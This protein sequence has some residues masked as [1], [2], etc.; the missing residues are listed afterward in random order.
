M[1][2]LVNYFSNYLWLGIVAFL[3]A[4]LLAR[5]LL[6]MIIFLSREKNLMDAPGERSAHFEKTPNL[7]GAGIF[8]AFSLSILILAGSFH[9]FLGNTNE[10]LILLAA[11]TITFFL[12]VKDD[13]I[14]ISAK[15]KLW[16]QNMAVSLVIL[17][18][19]LRI[20][21]LGGL[22]GI[23]EIPYFLSIVLT[24]L[25]F[26]FLINAFNLTD[27]VDGLASTVGILAC[28]TFG[29]FFLSAGKGL[30]GLLCI[31]LAGALLAFL[32]YN[33]SRKSKIFMGDSGSL[34]IGFMI[35]YLGIR[36]LQPGSSETAGLLI[37]D[38]YLPVLAVLSFPVTDTLRVAVLRL[39]RRRNPFKADRNHI[40]HRFLNSGFSHRQTTLFISLYNLFLIGLMIGLKSINIHLAF[41]I[42]I[43]LMCGYACLPR[44]LQALS[45][46]SFSTPEIW[47]QLNAF[48]RMNIW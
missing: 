30:Y 12:G 1:T 14:G 8:I 13:L 26:L 37:S 21:H 25:V 24:A 43:L 16:G 35:G 39:S 38:N 20:E 34:T 33:L 36:L 44:W 5:R 23:G 6:P 17:F 10:L 2:E 28:V 45:E 3:V 31:A 15:T 27:G 41:S 42:L 9:R 19:D 18:S 29:Y 48:I 46:T 11:I 4:F 7:G 22:F 40:H 32:K 47:K